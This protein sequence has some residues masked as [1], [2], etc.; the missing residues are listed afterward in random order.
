MKR[1]IYPSLLFLLSPYFLSAQ[2]PAG[3]VAEYQL[4][5]NNAN[6]ISGNNY[7]GSL[8]STTATSNRFAVTNRAIQLTSGSSTGT[9]PVVVMDNFS[10]GFWINTTMSAANGTEWYQGQSLVDAEVCGQVNDWGTALMNTGKIAFGI[11]NPDITI[12]S[13]SN[14]N[15]GNWHFITA[16]RDESAGVS[17]LYVDGSQV[18]TTNGLNTGPLNSPAI[19]GLGRNNCSGSNY[20][21]ALDDIIFY[22]RVLSSAEV[23]NLYNYSN[24]VTLP[25]NWLSFTGEIDGARINLNWQI[26]DAGLNKH[27]EVEHSMDAE[28]FS[29]I[30]NVLQNGGIAVSGGNL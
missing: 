3:F 22:N 25:L 18:A 11:G 27:F 30:G 17:V 28:N 13:A 21:G 2:K 4:D 9:L 15:D 24:A 19:I 1:I 20:T 5:N 23:T 29:V 7:T 26:A 16:T 6:D 8:T 10:L 14:Y 12:I